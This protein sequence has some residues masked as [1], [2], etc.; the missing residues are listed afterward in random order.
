MATRINT[1]NRNPIMRAMEW[2]FGWNGLILIIGISFIAVSIFKGYD[3]ALQAI[4]KT[5]SPNI[6]TGGSVVAG[7]LLGMLV[8]RRIQR[9]KAYRADHAEEEEV[10]IEDEEYD[11]DEEEAKVEA[12]AR[13]APPMTTCWDDPRAKLMDEAIVQLM[14]A[15]DNP[16][17][18]SF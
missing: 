8:F 17:C 6:F 15:E 3:R 7:I 12:F 18:V 4:L 14:S 10:F 16:K 2:F 5:L 9:N 1:Y 11:F 13:Q